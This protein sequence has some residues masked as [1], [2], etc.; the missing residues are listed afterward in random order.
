MENGKTY[1]M[2]DYF[3]HVIAADK[4]YERLNGNIRHKISSRSLYILGAQGGDVFFAYNMKLSHNN[5]GRLLHQQEPVVLFKKLY[6]GNPS[7]AA[8]F[9]TH[10]ALDS[11]IHPIV[12]A[13]EQGK[14]NPFSH[15]SFERDIG[16]YVSKFYCIRRTILPREYVLACTGPIYDTIKLAEPTITVTGV[17]RC[18]KRH[19]NYTR[20]LYRTKKQTYKCEYDFSLLAGIIED[21]IDLGLKAVEGVLTGDIDS[22]VFGRAFL[23]K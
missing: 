14:R 10:Y 6:L 17:E 8:G 12:Y 19:F 16:L 4:I 13:Y 15:Q 5:L 1:N 3:T 11:V 23:Q 22:E 18:L 2:P 21:G 7:Y 9:A 20:F